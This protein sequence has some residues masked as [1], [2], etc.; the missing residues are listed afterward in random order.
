MA[1]GSSDVPRGHSGYPPLEY[2][3]RGSVGASVT[4]LGSKA[5]RRQRAAC[6]PRMWHKLQDFDAAL[7]PRSGY[8][9]R[10]SSVS[11]VPCA[12]FN[13][14]A[15]R[16]IR[17]CFAS[18]RSDLRSLLIPTRRCTFMSRTLAHRSHTASRGKETRVLVPAGPC[19]VVS[20]RSARYGALLSCPLA[21]DPIGTGTPIHTDASM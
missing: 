10:G 19:L 18:F 21:R 9:A 16:F 12:S 14:H 13:S 7:A 6:L 17:Y 15:M 1:C 5:A 2:E 11:A 8:S 3:R 4:P 20:R